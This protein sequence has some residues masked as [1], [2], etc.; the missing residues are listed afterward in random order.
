MAR[1]QPQVA[2]ELASIHRFRDSVA[3]YVSDGKTTYL[4]P[5]VARQ[6]ARQLYACAR[7]VESRTFINSEFKTVDIELGAPT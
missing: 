7:D 6:I 1:K 5:K 2:R 3:L 4:D